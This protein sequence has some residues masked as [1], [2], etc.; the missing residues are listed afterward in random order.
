MSIALKKSLNFF[1]TRAFG[2]Q[3]VSV[4]LL[5]TPTIQFRIPLI[6]SEKF[7]YENEQK[8]ARD[9]PFVKSF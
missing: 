1:L 5:T 4:A 7:V 3:V 2:G 9:G 8:E 6:F